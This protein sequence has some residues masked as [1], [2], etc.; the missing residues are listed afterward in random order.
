MYNP[1]YDK[2][3]LQQGWQCPLCRMVWAPSVVS[4]ACNK[5]E[6]GKRKQVS[7]TIPAEEGWNL[8]TTIPATISDLD[9]KLINSLAVVDTKTTPSDKPDCL[10]CAC[11]TSI[12]LTS[13]PPQDGGIHCSA[14]G[15]INPTKADCP[16]M[17]RLV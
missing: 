7:N 8:S 3:P 17:I 13:N 1:N 10:N 14:C 12:V 5:N 6:V 2:L 11:A 9:I 15:K 4:C 16:G